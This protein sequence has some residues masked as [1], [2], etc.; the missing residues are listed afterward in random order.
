MSDHIALSIRGGGMRAVA[1][2]GAL[3]AFDEANVK[4]DSIVGV[5]GGAVVAAS[6]AFGK[7]PQE[8]LMH[9]KAFKPLSVLNPIGIF[10][11]SFLTSRKWEE[12]ARKLVSKGDIENAKIKLFIEAVNLDSGNVEFLNKGDAIKAIIA[13]STMIGSY[14]IGNKRYVDGG[15][16]PEF[17]VN[18]LKS[19]GID[20]VFGLILEESKGAYSI[21][22]KLVKPIQIMGENAIN[23]DIK[24]NPPDYL[25]TLKCNKGWVYGRNNLDYLFN[26]GYKATKEYLRTI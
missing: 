16:D 25:I 1:Y 3:Q 21:F 18:F 10:N 12:H 14:K 26:Q 20:K 9:F 11:G 22:S 4:L 8:I 15:Y 6:Y 2:A 24:L 5:S 13:S 7:T 23:M 19:Q 17:G